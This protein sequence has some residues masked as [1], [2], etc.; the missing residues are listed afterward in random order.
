M[1]L[2][3]LPVKSSVV[4]GEGCPSSTPPLPSGARGDT[5]PV[6][7]VICGVIGSGEGAVLAPE[8]ASPSVLGIQGLDSRYLLS[9]E[10]LQAMI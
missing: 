2:T 3:V 5:P 7:E 4:R 10:T 8:I 6:S 9:A 1:A